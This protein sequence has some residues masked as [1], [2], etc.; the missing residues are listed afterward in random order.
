VFRSIHFTIAG[1]SVVGAAGVL[2]S[3]GLR[4]ASVQ[5][6]EGVA[7]LVTSGLLALAVIGAVCR[8]PRERAWWL[9]F[10]VFGC[11]YLALAHWYSVHVASLPTVNLLLQP[12]ETWWS[13]LNAFSPPLRILHELWAVLVAVC[14]GMVTEVLFG[15]QGADEGGS[16]G[17]T[18]IEEGSSRSWWRRSALI[19]LVGCA[20]M[21]TAVLAGSGL[22]PRIW[23]GVTFL[24]TWGL[25]GVAL[26]G[27][28]F[29]L[30]R[31]REA[32]IGAVIFGIGYLVLTFGPLA[33]SAPTHHL[34]NA[35]FRPNYPTAAGELLD[36]ERTDDE[37]SRRIREALEQPI[38]IHFPDNTPVK[39]VLERI[40]SAAKGLVGKELLIYADPI[41]LA[42]A[43]VRLDLTQAS[44]D[45]ENTP[46]V[47]IDRESIPAREAL[48]LCL[49]PLGLTYRVQ[50][51]YVRIIPDEYRP[52]PVY[53]DPVM[54]GG[55]SLLS[56]I[57][58]AIGGVISPIIAGLCGRHGPLQG[59]TC[60]PDPRSSPAAPG[61]EA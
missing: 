48:R 16:V 5:T 50:A 11:G 34:L 49:S 24:L 37:E 51:G 44:I 38:S 6:W 26:M 25:L 29:G 59:P 33:Q 60:V 10:A 3:W 4:E 35:V 40:K 58:A 20:A 17:G 14:G 12:N 52:L 7:L 8:H 13:D 27:A 22:A 19:G 36:D 23:A 31:R 21:V 53:E 41:E 2:G 1:L 61:S 55:H 46:R 56:L 39:E 42:T 28:V 32:W 30:G 47:S 9:G 18:P 57:A 54:I 43:R 45:R 15:G